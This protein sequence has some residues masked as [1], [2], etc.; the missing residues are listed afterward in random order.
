MTT[1]PTPA[2]ASRPARPRALDVATSDLDRLVDG[3]HH[4]PH[5]ILGPHP[6]DGVVTV[7]VLRP[8][9]TDV[10]VVTQDAARHRMTHEHRGVWVAV[11]PVAEVPDYRLDVSYGGDP[12]PADDPYRFLPTLGEVDLHLI[13]EGRHEQ[14]W[15]VLGAHVRTFPSPMGDVTGTAFAVWAPNAVGVQVVGDFN[16]WDGA[17]TPMRSLGSS[18]VWE[19]FVPS[20]GDGTHYK[21]R[22]LGRDGGWR[23]KADPMAQATQ[24]PPQTAS[25]VFTSSYAWDDD[26]WLA[27][28]AEGNPHTG[29]MSTYEVHLG[30]WRMGLGYR[31]LAEELTAYVVEQG[32]THVELMPVAEHPFAPSWGYQV[33]SY[34]AP[35]SRFGSPDEFRHLV[36]RLHQAGIGVVM[37]WVPA[38]FPKDDWALA[39]FD[40]QPLYEHSDPRR[41]EHPD[42]G[43][44]VFDF[45]RTEVRNFL[46]ANAVYWL[47]EF[48]ID[49]LRVDAVASMLYLDYSRKDGEWYPNQYGGRENLDAV[50][51]LQEMNATVYKRVPG[52]VTIAEES[53]AWPGVTR[54]THLGGLGFGLKWNMGWMHD[55]LAYIGRE[56]VHRQWHHN[57]MT[58]ALMYAWSEAFVLPIS[59]DEVVHGKG[60]LV[61]RM[62]G[63]RWQQLANLR[64]YLG[65]MWGHPGKQL[66]FMGSEFAQSDEWSEARGL[67][68]WLLDFPEHRGVLDCVRDLN[69]VYRESPAL[70]SLDHEPRG[71]E[72]IDANDAAGNVFSWL[73]WGADG[74]VVACVSNLSPVVRADYRLGLPA[75]GT[76]HEVLNTDAAEYGGSGVGNLGAVSTE[77]IWWHGKPVSASLTVPPLSTL[78]LRFDDSAAVPD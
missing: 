69:A 40:G 74:S 43:T 14:L 45:G 73:R 12:I 44:L 28:R 10:T 54:P 75:A 32:F 46:V 18:G 24:V 15:D 41:G 76:W 70:W 8:G 35:T 61:A 25:V 53:T 56:A 66:L 30:S 57:E 38:H 77:E 21:F 50:S 4:D 36:D 49:G 67:D 26:A 72:W 3:A 78:W 7:R 64:A 23:E 13:G 20:I 68:W 62:P 27:A 29:P 63:D 48:H 11:L 58:F 55:S 34:F 51:F 52:V 65:Y 17:A 31:E 22:I 60:S 59:H 6:H 5:G 19:V 42:W 37:D 16:G 39:R 33:T 71:F 1:G 9:A 2:P 47:E